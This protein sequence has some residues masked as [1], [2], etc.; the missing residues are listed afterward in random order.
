VERHG[1]AWS[2]DLEHLIDALRSKPRALLHCRL[3]G[4][5]QVDVW[6]QSG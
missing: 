3:S 2:I 1:R 4:V 5:N 6:R